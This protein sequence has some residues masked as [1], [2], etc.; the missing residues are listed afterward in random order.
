MFY[1]EAAEGGYLYHGSGNSEE[2]VHGFFLDENI[3]IIQVFRGER[4]GRT[5]VIGAGR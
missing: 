2:I 1:G 4:P 3:K 5:S